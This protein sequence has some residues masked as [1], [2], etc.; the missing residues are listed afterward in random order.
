VQ[1]RRRD[2]KRAASTLLYNR[3]AA[4]FIE[5]SFTRH[6]P[7]WCGRATPLRIGLI[8]DIHY[9][10]EVDVRVGRAA[11]RLAE[12]FRRRR[13]TDFQPDLSVD[14]GNR[15]ND[16]DLDADR[17]RLGNTGLDPQLGWLERG[18]STGTHAIVFCHHPLDAHDASRHR[19]S[20]D[21]HDPA[22]ANK[23]VNRF[24]VRAGTWRGY[25]SGDPVPVQE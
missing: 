25:N 1:V 23:G 16:A 12:K 18:L 2:V 6:S 5:P 17:R 15:I 3:H 19:Y 11:L 14:M 22:S 8:T 4:G 24:A 21:H 20:K 7:A 10:R 13:R 9:G